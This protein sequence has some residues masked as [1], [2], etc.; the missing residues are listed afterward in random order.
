MI[1][2]YIRISTNKQH[3][4]NQVFEINK[5]AAENNIHID[6]W[7]RETISSTRELKKRKLG[8]LIRQLGP[9]DI[10]IA[11][12]I[13]RLGRNML[14]LMSLLHDCMK[15]GAQ[16]W[17]L[18]DNY[19]LGSNLE[20]KI[21]AFAFGLSAEIERNLIAER[22]RKALKRLKESGQPLGRRPGSKNKNNKMERRAKDIRVMLDN[23]L[24]KAQIARI[25][26]VNR[27]TV[28]RYLKRQ[29]QAKSTPA[30]TG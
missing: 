13:S 8:A 21:L 16:V 24:P 9:D 22:T 26:R 6:R 12:E 18:K 2:G 27:L 1:Y 20:S 29:E 14:Q 23:G 3:V 10:I 30:S 15:S 25:L 17:T 28:Y 5:F 4:A 7:I 19:R 11:T